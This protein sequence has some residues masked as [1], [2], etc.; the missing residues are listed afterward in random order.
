MRNW[1]MMIDGTFFGL[2]ARYLRHP[3]SPIDFLIHVKDRNMLSEVAKRIELNSPLPA[4]A[5]QPLAPEIRAMAQDGLVR[6]S[7]R[8]I[9]DNLQPGA[10]LD[11][12]RVRQSAR[13]DVIY[14]PPYYLVHTP[15]L[16]EGKVM[17]ANPTEQHQ[18]RK[19]NA[20]AFWR[21]RHA[22]RDRG[23]GQS[24]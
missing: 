10:V 9:L 4:M 23:C 1:N 19:R 7:S 8:H 24:N 2:V 17:T 6:V 15:G 13:C 22:G 3:Y 14:L 18:A 12:T 20:R 5:R 16:F 21:P 11:P